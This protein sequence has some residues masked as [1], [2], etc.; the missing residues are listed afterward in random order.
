MKIDT[1]SSKKTL[2]E[3]YLF[4]LRDEKPVD[5]SVLPRLKMRR[6]QSCPTTLQEFITIKK[7]K[8]DT[9]VL[10]DELFDLFR[11]YNNVYEIS[12]YKPISA[13]HLASEYETIKL[14][15]FIT[16]LFTS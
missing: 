10:R 14:S 12:E 9:E 13:L 15:D 1:S 6:S 5:N 8:T 2:L 4:E 3:T 7:D 16:L 11:K